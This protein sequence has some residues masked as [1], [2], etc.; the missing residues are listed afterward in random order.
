[1]R[2]KQPCRHKG[3]CRRR[4][5][6]APGAEQKSP[7]AQ[8]RPMVEQ[9]V[10]QQLMGALYRRSPHAHGG[11]VDEAWRRLQPMEIYCRSSPRPELHPWGGALGGAGGL[12]EQC[13]AVPEGW[14]LWYR[15]V[16]GQ[17]L[18]SCSLWETHK[19]QFRRGGIPWEGPMLSR[20]RVTMEEEWLLTTAPILHFSVL[21]G[22]V[23]GGRGWR[24]KRCF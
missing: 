12:G 10:P 20:G 8:K 4:A 18:E 9:P 16:L 24:G 15:A 6:G 13:W 19:D 23:A 3:Q 17:C 2:E 11:T 1:M 7:S 22:G 5:R 21:L 14:A